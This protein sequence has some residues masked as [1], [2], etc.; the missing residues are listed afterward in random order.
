MPSDTSDLWKMLV[1]LGE[2]SNG[3]VG[4]VRQKTG[5]NM[6]LFVDD[7]VLA[8]GEDWKAVKGGGRILSCAFGSLLMATCVMVSRYLWID[9]CGCGL[10]Y[11][12]RRRCKYDV[13]PQT[14]RPDSVHS[15]GTK[16]LVPIS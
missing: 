4:R 6:I 7:E 15:W 5:R 11:H 2:D 1:V 10:T 12:L 3:F 16:H 9:L 13:P 14:H 8:N